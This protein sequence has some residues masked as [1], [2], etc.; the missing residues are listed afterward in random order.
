MLSQD[1]RSVAAALS[2]HDS[3]ARLD[4]AFHVLADCHGRAD[5]AGFPEALCD[6]V[7]GSPTRSRWCS[8]PGTR[9][10]S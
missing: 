9:A 10:I 5:T 7:Q 8:R 3:P 1:L 2:A 4:A 6:L